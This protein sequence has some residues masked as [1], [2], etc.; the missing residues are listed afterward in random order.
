V[1]DALLLQV[2]QF[3][4][5]PSQ[6]MCSN[7]LALYPRTGL[8]VQLPLPFRI[9]FAQAKAGCLALPVKQG[10]AVGFEVWR[11]VQRGDP[12]GVGFGAEREQASSCSS[13]VRKG[14]IRGCRLRASTI[15]HASAG[16]SPAASAM[17]VVPSEGN[18][19][20]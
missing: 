10:A 5:D 13:L 6:L 15:E 7:R 4:V 8:S 11:N 18:C 20:A 17:F 9:D 2:V 19:H 3:A 12:L 1:Q 14:D 16:M